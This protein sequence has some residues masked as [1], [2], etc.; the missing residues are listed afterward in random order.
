MSS[1]AAVLP[2]SLSRRLQIYRMAARLKRRG[3]RTLAGVPA[4]I[5]RSIDPASLRRL[6]EEV[7]PEYRRNP[8]SAAKY[9]IPQEW[10][11]LN[12]LRA[13]ELGL[14][15]ATGLRILDIGC[16]PAFFVAVTRALGHETEAVD[17]PQAYMTAVEQRVYSGLIE[18]LKCERYVTPLLIERYVPL[19]YPENRFDLIT[20]FWICFNRHRQPD[21]WGREEWRFFV[22]DAVRK[23][24]PG[25][26]IYLDLN[27]NP[28]RYGELRFYDTPTLEYFQ[29]VGTVD[30][31]RV[32]V[33]RGS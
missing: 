3:S 18:I 28:E 20:A 1:V 23:L 32:S 33:K 30:G 15:T 10:L 11:L 25:G 26:R 17:A 5:D 12:A 4:A 24:R 16:G 9:A 6:W 8:T 7:E 31:G 27:E 19:P 14:D 13:G 29:S 2:R 21:E 22:E